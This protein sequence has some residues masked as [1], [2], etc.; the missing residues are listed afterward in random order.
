ML[1]P[2]FIDAALMSVETPALIVVESLLADSIRVIRKGMDPDCTR[3]LFSLKPLSM[4]TVL[5]LL[6]PSVD[7]FSA[8][9]P[10]E[11]QLAYETCGTSSQVHFSSPGLKAS[12][13]PTLLRCCTS[14][15]F[16]SLIQYRALASSV[17][18]SIDCG[19]RVNPK[20]SLVRDK[21]YDP[22]RPDSRLGVPLD[23]LEQE[24]QRNV[25]EF[26]YVSGLHFHNNCDSEDLDGYAKTV[27]HLEARLPKL[28][29][30]LKWVNLGGG[31]I[32]TNT[33]DMTPLNDAIEHL[34]SMYGLTAFV[35][36]GASVVR[37]AGYIV[38]SVIDIVSNNG[39]EVAI[40]DT[41]VNHMPEVFEYQF[42]PNVLGHRDDGEYEY[43]LAGC[44][45]LAG[46]VFGT[47][48]FD[49]PL[50]IGQKITFVDMGAYT[51][52]KANMFNGIPLPNIYMLKSDGELLL[53]RQF[54]YGDYLSFQGDARHERA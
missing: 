22:C 40:L 32:F 52:V 17:V 14:V 12:H 1:T 13:V 47:Y 15:S 41:T 50:K 5:E 43:V 48:A 27:L 2:H 8:S 54:D 16:N 35:E 46:D 49:E 31:Y 25:S 19:I 37:S 23:R 11:A 53:I 34:H 33:T 44:S 21:R 42:E 9:S 36:P 10:F 6:A 28:F 51:L 26:G 39:N 45:C 20:I 38:S 7:G 29:R 24:V 4:R 3:L 18:G 30:Q